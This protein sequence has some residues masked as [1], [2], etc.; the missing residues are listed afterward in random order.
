MPTAIITPHGRVIGL[1]TLLGMIPISRT[2]IWRLERAGRF[3]KRLQL[4]A[5]RVGWDVEDIQ[6]WIASK[7]EE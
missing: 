2:T 1:K 7:K 4:T 5:N 3:P 6:R